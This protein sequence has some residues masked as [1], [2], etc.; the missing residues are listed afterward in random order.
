MKN[1]HRSWFHIKRLWSSVSLSRSSIWRA[2]SNQLRRV[3]S[4]LPCTSL[5]WTESS[6]CFTRTWDCE[7][8]RLRS[9]PRLYW[10]RTIEEIQMF[11]RSLAQRSMP[12]PQSK[13]QKQ[14]FFT[15]WYNIFTTSFFDEFRYFKNVKEHLSA[16]VLEHLPIN[17]Q[18]L[19]EAVTSNPS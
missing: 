11:R 6:L 7:L 5:S 19:N 3:T 13:F 10:T 1:L 9:L 8:K 4:E 17:L 15:E 14:I 18:D 2:I 16:S 12:M